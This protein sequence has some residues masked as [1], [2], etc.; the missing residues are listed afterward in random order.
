M[1]WWLISHGVWT[2][3]GKLFVTLVTSAGPV[4]TVSYSNGVSSPGLPLGMLTASRDGTRIA[5][6]CYGGN[7]I[8][9]WNFNRTTGVPTTLLAP[10]ASFGSYSDVCFI[11]TPIELYYISNKKYTLIFSYFPKIPHFLDFTALTVFSYISGATILDHIFS[12]KC[13]GF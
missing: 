1:D 8:G 2:T 12:Q 13:S 5:A 10:T 6:V 7:Q 11:K 9:V 4:S 3:N